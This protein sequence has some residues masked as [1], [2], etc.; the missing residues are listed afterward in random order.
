MWSQNDFDDK[1]E[2][3]C[4]NVQFEMYTLYDEHLNSESTGKQLHLVFAFHMF[5]FPNQ[6]QERN[7]ICNRIQQH[8]NQ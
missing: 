5:V 7:M 3:K 4:N 1:K 6:I 8:V 2:K